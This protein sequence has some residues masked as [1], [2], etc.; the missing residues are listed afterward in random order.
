MRIDIRYKSFLQKTK[1][2]MK[3]DITSPAATCIGRKKKRIRLITKMWWPSK[4]IS[5]NILLNWNSQFISDVSKN[6]KYSD[7]LFYGP[8]TRWDTGRKV[9]RCTA[10]Q[11]FFY[12][13]NFCQFGEYFNGQRL[14]IGSGIK[15]F[16]FY[17]WATSLKE[18][19]LTVSIIRHL[20]RLSR[21]GSR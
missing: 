18:P 14:E 1:Y 12:A 6:N 4:V 13:S 17:L 5:Q 11:E 3:I 2:W 20:C 7:T 8:D 9:A 15:N 16:R 10:C 21:I 19:L